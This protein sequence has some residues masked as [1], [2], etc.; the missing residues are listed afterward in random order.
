[1]ARKTGFSRPGVVLEGLERRLLRVQ[2]KDGVVA[3]CR[4]EGLCKVTD[5]KPGERVRLGMPVLGRSVAHRERAP[6]L[7]DYVRSHSV[8]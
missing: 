7:T 1:M 8:R 2:R 4:P 3:L 5:Y 6:S